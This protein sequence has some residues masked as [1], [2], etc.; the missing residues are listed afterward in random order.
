[1]KLKDLYP[2]TQALLDQLASACVR[3]EIAGSLRRGKRDPKDIEL[4]CIP[5]IGEY[6]VPVYE[7]FAA[8]AATVHQ[9]NHLEDALMTLIQAGAWE[10]DPLVRRNGP[11]Y[12]RLRH[13]ASGICCDLF[14][15]DARRWGVIFAIRTGPANFSQA[16]VRYARRQSMFVADGL[17]HQHAPEGYDADGKALPCPAG[18]RCRRIVETPEEIDV[19]AAL[20]LLWI[21]P[22]RRNLNLFYASRPRASWH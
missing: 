9:V 10:F 17:L 20:G 5:S 14:I 2:I 6:S 3:I 12:K 16:L 21:E 1:M 22:A 7:M 13:G 19:F 4:V 15:T 18:E 11:R 8:P